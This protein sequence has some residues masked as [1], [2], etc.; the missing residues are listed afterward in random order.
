[1]SEN[2]QRRPGHLWLLGGL[3][4]FHLAFNSYWLSATTSVD[5]GL[6]HNHLYQALAHAEGIAGARTWGNPDS[7]IY[8]LSSLS[9]RLFGP[10]YFSIAFVHTLFF[11]LALV[12]A[13]LLAGELAGPPAGLLAAALL[14]L[15]P[16]AFGLSRVYSDLACG[17]MIGAW[18]LWLLW[19]T[20]AATRLF[21]A[22]LLAALLP[23][24]MAQMFVPSHGMLIVLMLAGPAAVALL[25]RTEEASWTRKALVAG[26]ALTMLAVAASLCLP[27]P[28]DLSYYAGESSR[29]TAASLSRH[30]GFVFSMLLL[31][32]AYVQGPLLFGA[33]LFGAA[34]A[35]VRRARGRWFLSAAIVPTLVVLTIVPKR[36]DMNLFCLL[37]ALAVL[38]AVGLMR[39][40][41]RGWRRVFIGVLLCAAFGQFLYGSLAPRRPAGLIERLGL[42]EAYEA[43][44]YPWMSPPERE[45]PVHRT[46]AAL[47]EAAASLAP[48]PQPVRIAT[49]GCAMD[50]TL[51]FE[52]ALQ[53]RRLEL[54]QLCEV[55]QP[56]AVL[57]EADMLLLPAPVALAE[58]ETRLSAWLDAGL[59]GEV[60]AA[61]AALAPHCTWWR[62]SGR[63]GIFIVQKGRPK[64]D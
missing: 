8:P 11:L 26:A 15:T 10:S 57:T 43:P 53:S 3:L 41:H 59:T 18:S 29:F 21:P 40:R 51:R 46:A 63:E 60:R 25:G 33:L 6:P 45:A 5:I 31:W 62:R 42:R 28:F 35:F 7:L 38:T 47:A 14:S 44:P 4:L 12:G 49:T 39:I 58:D 20:R 50:D 22:L 48:Q 27:R 36:K 52:L 19:R 37:P 56:A 16:A 61:L 1:M 9:A 30:P 23:C 34:T 24:G 54:V 2:G 64:S 17:M 55:E 32:A 13:Y